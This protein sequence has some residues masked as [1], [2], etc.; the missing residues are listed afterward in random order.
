[1][2]G[3]VPPP[4]DQAAI[5]SAAESAAP[6]AISSTEMDVSNSVSVAAEK[7]QE[8]M[9]DASDASSPLAP[10]AEVA[11]KPKEPNSTD[12]AEPGAAGEGTAPERRKRRRNRKYE[13][14]A[15]VAEPYGERNRSTKE[16]ASVAKPSQANTP[17][18]PSIPPRP[19]MDQP[20]RA[21]VDTT[22][23]LQNNIALSLATP[24][25]RIPKGHTFPGKSVMFAFDTP[26][27]SPNDIERRLK[28]LFLTTTTKALDSPS[29]PVPILPPKPVAVHQLPHSTIHVLP[30]VHSS[31][32]AKLFGPD[33]LLGMQD[34]DDADL[35]TG[36]DL[37]HIH[38]GQKGLQENGIP[39]RIKDQVDAVNRMLEQEMPKRI[40]A[41]ENLY[42]EFEDLIHLANVLYRITP[43]DAIKEFEVIRASLVSTDAAPS[44]TAN[45][46]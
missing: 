30:G 25:I 26:D 39:A 24:V 13:D 21:P 44:S 14:A 31:F 4:P 15:F 5:A 42:G 37:P 43:E 12:A 7:S 20:V 45:P 34:V 41:Y 32:V 33:S 29:N 38:A 22:V 23:S 8:G 6:M 46:A 11:E 40:K 18:I 17:P 1:M 10:G 27:L 16:K 9:K 35:P 28:G 2:E 19:T 3:F 36:F